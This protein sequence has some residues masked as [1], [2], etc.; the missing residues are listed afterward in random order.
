MGLNAVQNLTGGHLAR[1]AQHRGH[2]H[3][4]FMGGH[5]L[6]AEGCRLTV[7]PGAVFRSVIG[8]IPDDG[9]VGQAIVIEN[10]RIADGIVM[11]HQAPIR[12]VDL[13][14]VIL[15]GIAPLVVQ[16]D[17]RCPRV[18]FSQTKK[19]LSPS[20]ALVMNSMARGATSPR[21]RSSS[22]RGAGDRYP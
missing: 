19:G 2:P 5:L 10:F 7:R 14:G 15:G 12:H 4:A 8:R 1:P 16:P 21:R 3:A 17:V 18:G 22:A 20:L 13:G 9:V 11:L 6:A